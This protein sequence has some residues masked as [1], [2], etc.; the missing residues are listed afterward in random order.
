MPVYAPSIPRFFED[1]GDA[2]EGM[3]WATV[4]GTYGDA[5]GRRFATSYERAFCAAARSARTPASLTTASSC[6][7]RAW[8][9]SDNPRN[10]AEVAR[11]LRTNTHRGVNGSYS[12]DTDGQCGLAYP[13]A[14]VD[15]SLGQAHL[16]FQIRGGRHHVLSP[17]P[18]VEAS[19]RSPPWCG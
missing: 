2:A 18:Y 8:A 5:L 11:R 10:F 14:V 7:T 17:S 13:D 4:S 9:E 19:F 16:V 15:P 3:V 1:A 12:F 6:S